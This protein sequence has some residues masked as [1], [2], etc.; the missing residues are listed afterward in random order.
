MNQAKTAK[1]LTAVVA[2]LAI[3]AA[4]AYIVYGNLMPEQTVSGSAAAGQ[5]VLDGSLTRLSTAENSR[6]RLQAARWIGENSKTINANVVQGLSHALLS[7]PD[8]TVRASVATTLGTLAA[9]GNR[10]TANVSRQEPLMMEALSLAYDRE[11]NASVRR[12]L[13]ESAGKFNEPAAGALLS[14]ALVDADSSV[15]EAAQEAKLA[16]DRRLVAATSG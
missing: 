4:G 5:D 14:K 15:R 8:P 7:D 10:G 13:V 9:R 11:S 12:C 3:L 2:F 1:I 16:R 6:E